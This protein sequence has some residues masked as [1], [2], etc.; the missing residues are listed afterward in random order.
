MLEM[1][2]QGGQDEA[3]AFLEMLRAG[4][5]E[6]QV[7]GSR[8]RGAFWHVYA[9]VRAPQPPGGPAPEAPIRVEAAVQRRALGRRPG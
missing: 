9:V 1:R 3:L 7:G 6:V 8:N 4:G 5:V 2:L